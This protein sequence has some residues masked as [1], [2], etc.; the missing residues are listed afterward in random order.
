[1]TLE[2]VVV[3]RF[4]WA[5]TPSRHPRRLVERPALG[6]RIQRLAAIYLRVS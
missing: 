4:N 6:A 1:M 2:E 3:G 5:I